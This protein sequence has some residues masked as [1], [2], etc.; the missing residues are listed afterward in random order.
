[1]AEIRAEITAE[2]GFEWVLVS[3]STKTR[4]S[5]RYHGQ[6]LLYEWMSDDWQTIGTLRDP[7]DKQKAVAIAKKVMKKYGFTDP[8]LQNFE[9]RF[10]VYQFGGF[11]LND[12]GLWSLAGKPAEVS[13]GDLYFQIL[14]LNHDHTKDLTKQS[15]ANVQNLGWQ[16]E[17]LSVFYSGDFMLSEVDKAE[18]EKRAEPYRGKVAPPP[19][20][21]KD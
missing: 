21:N 7:A 6:S 5:N 1:M 18:F 12:Q 3:K 15:Q 13:R 16:P 2:F 4:E 17:Y 11:T 19:G 20:S 10:A 14:D 8:D 9:G